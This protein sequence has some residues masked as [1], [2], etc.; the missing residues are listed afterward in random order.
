MRYLRTG[1][2]KLCVS[3][4]PHGFA[5]WYREWSRS[6][7]EREKEICKK[8]RNA[9]TSLRQKYWMTRH[10]LFCAHRSRS[11]FCFPLLFPSSSSLVHPFAR[12]VFYER[13]DFSPAVLFHALATPNGATR[14]RLYHTAAKIFCQTFP[15]A[16]G[17]PARN[18]TVYGE[19]INAGVRRDEK[20][21]C[22]QSFPGWIKN[23]WFKRYVLRE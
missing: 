15:S 22:L 3:S 10:A 16:T 12:D 7:R 21:F 5:E 17:K 4:I 13:L 9:Y 11:S 23:M 14:K 8:N 1:G 6:K 19:L 2:W 18:F 20:K